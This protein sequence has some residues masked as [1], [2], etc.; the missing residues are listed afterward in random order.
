MYIYLA[1]ETS[2]RTLFSRQCAREYIT[3]LSVLYGS[4]VS[5]EALFFTWKVREQFFFCFL[6]DSVKHIRELFFFFFQNM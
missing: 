3:R 1:I 2:R 6:A 5:V 4:L